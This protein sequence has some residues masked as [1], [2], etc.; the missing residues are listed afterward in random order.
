[1]SYSPTPLEMAP[2]PVTV[3]NRALPP[4][5]ASACSTGVGKAAGVTMGPESGAGSSVG[6]DT[7]TG[8]RCCTGEGGGGASWVP[9]AARVVLPYTTAVTATPATRPVVG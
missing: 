5:S 6:N 3:W 8:A 4:V 2:C 9:G 7:V 1:M